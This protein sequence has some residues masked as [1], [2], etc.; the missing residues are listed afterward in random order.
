MNN[1]KKIGFSKSL[2]IIGTSLLMLLSFGAV[3]IGTL[4]AAIIEFS[5]D[6]FFEF[7]DTENNNLVYKCFV[8]DE[9]NHTV[10]IKWS[11]RN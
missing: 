8:V 1:L 5:E 2:P 3:T 9:E 6:T 7:T 4:S 10:A 11:D